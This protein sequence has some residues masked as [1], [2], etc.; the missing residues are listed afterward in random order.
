MQACRPFAQL[1]ALAVSLSAASAAFAATPTGNTVFRGSATGS[2]TFT[3]SFKAT[4]PLSFTVAS[5]GKELVSF[6]YSDTVCDLASS[7]VVQVGVVKLAADGSFA[8]ASVK[9]APEGDALED[10][11]KVVTTTTLSGK[12][13]SP[14]EATGTLDYSQKENNSAASH[15]GPIKLAFTAT[16]S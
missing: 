13:V 2:V 1:A 11:H 4:D 5:G 16:A 6:S 10:G 9:S 14:S 7:K 8:V 15:C 3:T 12:F